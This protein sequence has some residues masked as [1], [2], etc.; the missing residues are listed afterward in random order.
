[1][2][3]FFDIPFLNFYLPCGT[4]GVLHKNMGNYLLFNCFDLFIVS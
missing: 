1:M 2:S 3:G 4:F